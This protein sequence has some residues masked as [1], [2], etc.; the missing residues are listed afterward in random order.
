LE[1]SCKASKEF[2]SV[3]VVDKQNLPNKILIERVKW[4]LKEH[5]NIDSCNFIKPYA[6]PMS[7]PKLN[8][9]QYE[10]RPSE[11]RLTTNIFLAGDTELNGSL[12][13]AM[14]SGERAALG[15]IETLSNSISPEFTS[16]YH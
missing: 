14:I 4:E 15:I 7:L 2:L 6:I 12:N 3:T 11:T 8:D 13:A 16:E 9:L 10:V 5:C 1:T